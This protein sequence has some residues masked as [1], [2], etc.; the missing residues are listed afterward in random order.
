MSKMFYKISQLSGRPTAY[1]SL[2]RELFFGLPRVQARSM[3]VLLCL[4]PQRMCVF[5]C[6]YANV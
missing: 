2:I 4:A 3:R 6:A 1:S 5:V